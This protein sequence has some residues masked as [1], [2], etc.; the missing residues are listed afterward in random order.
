VYRVAPWISVEPNKT[1]AAILGPLPFKRETVAL[2]IPRTVVPAN[3]GGILIFAWVGLSG[4]NAPF[5]Y[6]HFAS[7]LADGSQNWFSM[8]IAGDTTGQ[9]VTS[10]SQAFWLPQP[11]DGKLIVTLFANDLTSP[12]NGGQVEIHGYYPGV[13][14]A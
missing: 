13:P 11:A 10:N 5:A 3:A 7:T 12:S 1:P 2:A 9:S 6:W 4:K 8:L 14:T